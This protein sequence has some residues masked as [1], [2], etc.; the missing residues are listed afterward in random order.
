MFE[1]LTK[2]IDA[3][4]AA[5]DPEK[6]RETENKLKGLIDRHDSDHNGFYHRVRSNTPQHTRVSIELTFFPRSFICF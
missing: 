6:Y 4:A 3:K 1:L 5:A 2:D